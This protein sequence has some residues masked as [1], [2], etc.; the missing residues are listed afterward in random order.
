MQLRYCDACSL[1]VD[2]DK[3]V[4]AGDKT[5]C[6]EC[7]AKLAPA[8]KTPGASGV[9][10]AARPATGVRRSSPPT[11]V[12]RHTPASGVQRAAG[13]APAAGHSPATGSHGAVAPAPRK[14]APRTGAPQVP[15]DSPHP[16][17]SGVRGAATAEA[18]AAGSGRT[19]TWVVAAAGLLLALLGVVLMT[20]GGRGSQKPKP[21]ES[22][23]EGA[24]TLTTLQAKAPGV[25]TQD[26]RTSVTGS[27]TLAPGPRSEQHNGTATAQPEEKT[28]DRPLKPK[29]G[30]FGGGQEMEDIRES[31]ARSE[32]DKILEMEKSGKANPFELR[33]R[34]ERFLDTSSYRSTKYGKEAEER[35]KSL[36]PVPN[37]PPDNP[38]ATEP[39]LLARSFEK[40][41]GDIGLSGFSPDGYKQIKT[42]VA[43][44]IDHGKNSGGLPEL[45]DGR[46]EN[47]IVQFT[48]FIEAPR[49]GSYVFFTESDD[50]S[51]LYI[52]DMLLVS[53]DGAHAMVKQSCE[54]PL[55]AGKHRFRVDFWQGKGDFGLVVSWSGPDF[56][57]QTIPA[58]SFSHTP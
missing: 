13:P 26:T 9:R 10:G 25:G 31:S 14:P 27:Q 50:G 15:A 43:P 24:K 17:Q 20:R 45:A 16:R 28:E 7:A 33:R 23:R 6:P 39:G 53:N 22:G 38:G 52:G 48:G 1:R 3:A 29:S 35:F 56:G 54:I 51:V 37:R 49:D 5:Y 58:A 36:P 4:S 32:F 46:R 21:R 55:K 11:G 19:L 42:Q 47:I 57:E 44:N 40:G 41:D 30:L 18:G 12:V 2:T 34:Y 8:R